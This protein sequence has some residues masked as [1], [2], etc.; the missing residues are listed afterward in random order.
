LRQRAS[1][2]QRTS[3]LSKLSSIHMGF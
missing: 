2:N 3:Q 1:G